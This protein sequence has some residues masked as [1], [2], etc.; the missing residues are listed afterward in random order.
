MSLIKKYS[1]ANKDGANWYLEAHNFCK[2]VSENYN[3][4]LVTVCAVMSALSPAT[5]YEQNKKDTVNLIKGKRG[6]KCTTYG[7]NVK[8]ARA[9]L[10]DGIPRFSSKTGAKTYNFFFNL[11]EPDN[12]AFIC[13]DRHAY[14]IATGET[15]KGLT[16]KQ[17]GNVA[18]QYTKAAKKLGILP[19]ELQAVLW[20]DYRHKEEIKFKEFTPF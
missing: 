4:S 7:A 15:Y 14:V 8:K 20:V 17:Y 11:L 13:V 5:N 6:Y 16:P 19:N 3:V 12:S 18:Q 1:S 10:K 9:I 2:Q